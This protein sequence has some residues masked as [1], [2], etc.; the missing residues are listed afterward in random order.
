[1]TPTRVYRI[2][3]R[4]GKPVCVAA[5]RISITGSW[6]TIRHADGSE[7]SHNGGSFGKSDPQWFL[8]RWRESWIEA[9]LS[10][11]NRLF[12]LAGI[13]SEAE[14]RSGYREQHWDVCE[15]MA[16]EAMRMGELAAAIDR[17]KAHD[18]GGER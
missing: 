3:W 8:G 12:V 2:V 7:T 18:T 10:E 17:A 1:M 16:R 5:D 11:A 9:W 4:D 15:A 6:W 13:E 14:H